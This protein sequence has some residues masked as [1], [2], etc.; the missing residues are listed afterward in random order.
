M[1]ILP[2]DK[3]KDKPMDKPKKLNVLSLKFPV[4]TMFIAV[5][6]RPIPHQ[7]FNEKILME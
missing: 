2:K 5:V 6:A 4:K 3:H 7:N 1:Q